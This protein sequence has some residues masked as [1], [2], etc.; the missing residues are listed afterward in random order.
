MP[1]TSF[2]HFDHTALDALEANKK[3]VAEVSNNGSIKRCGQWIKFDNLKSF[4]ITNQNTPRN[5]LPLLEIAKL[6]L[7][8]THRRET[9]ISWAV[10][11]WTQEISDTS[12]PPSKALPDTNAPLTPQKRDDGRQR[13]TLSPD[14]FQM[15]KKHNS[16]HKVDEKIMAIINKPKKVQ[17]TLNIVYIF[18]DA[19]IPHKFKVG[20][21]TNR[22]GRF[23]KWAKC[24]PKLVVHTLTEC[25]D[26]KK[27]EKLVHAEL[28][29]QRQ[30]HS[31][32]LCDSKPVSHGEWFEKDLDDIRR[33]VEGWAAFVDN[34]YH[35]N[36]YVKPEYKSSFAGSSQDEGRWQNWIRGELKRNKIAAAAAQ[37][38]EEDLTD[39]GS[40]E[41]LAT[42]QTDPSGTSE[43]PPS[44]I[45]HIPCVF[46][47][48]EEHVGSMPSAR[49]TA[50]TPKPL[51][52]K[53]SKEEE[54][55]VTFFGL[56]KRIVSVVAGYSS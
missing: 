41:S 45:L 46:P 1:V 10:D 23:A 2:L 38:L 55:R 43:A 14:S 39:S 19:N 8:A 13:A 42:P 30:K 34:A 27:V 52:G 21:T 18:S 12:C 47:T 24:Y 35:E 31:C 32:D 15:N 6:C 28:D 36:G 25:T 33:I 22:K 48:V 54:E 16:P 29:Q 20:H 49:E 5:K 44:P 7:C 53:A 26:A 56:A 11:Q 9:N 50:V 40:S 51:G 4:Y 37:E 3:C 17:G